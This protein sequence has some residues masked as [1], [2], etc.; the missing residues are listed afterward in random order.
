MKQRLNVMTCAEKSTSCPHSFIFACLVAG[1]KQITDMGHIS[2]H[3]YF[4]L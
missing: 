2:S 4:N 3:A 1:N